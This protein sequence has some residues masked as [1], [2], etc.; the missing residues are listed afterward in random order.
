MKKILINI[1]LIVVFTGCADNTTV[2]DQTEA[3][4]GSPENQKSQNDT[5]P[6]SGDKPVKENSIIG[7]WHQLYAVFDQNGNAVPDP[8]DRNGTKSS[9]GFN[10]FKFNEDGSC[11]RDSDAKFRGNYEIVNEQGKRQLQI[12][13]NG[14]GET[15]RYTIIDPVASELIL[16][17][18]GVFMI[19]KKQ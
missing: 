1:L 14:F 5:K 15:Y 11:L 7:E 13:V 2:N 6:G 9:M 3:F 18:S 17:S 4:N 10:Y 8:E 12:T 16:Y 19:Y